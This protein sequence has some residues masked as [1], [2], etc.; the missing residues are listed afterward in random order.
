MSSVEKRKYPSPPK[1][2]AGVFIFM[3]A[4]LAFFT[5]MALF[6]F[7]GS[8][9]IP[10][11][12]ALAVLVLWLPIIGP[13]TLKVAHWYSPDPQ[14]ELI[15]SL[16]DETPTEFAD[17][18]RQ[19]DRPL[20]SLGFRLAGD[21]RVSNAM[22]GGTTFVALFEN[23]KERQVAQVITAI[24]VTAHVRKTVTLLLFSTEF[25]DQTK[26]S[27][28]NSPQSI[29]IPLLRHREGSHSFP[30]I[31]SPHR[32]FEI[33]QASIARFGGDA[34]RVAP[35]IDDPAEFL[36]R[37][38]R[39]EADTFVDTGYYYED[40]KYGIYRPTWRG[41]CL[42]AWKSTWP[43]KPIRQFVRKRRAAEFLR[44]LGLEH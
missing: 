33:H 32:L 3:S 34:A 11:W 16:I 35:S 36:R 44:A 8:G 23:A 10:V 43:I 30:W 20:E 2:S 1:P 25:N 7:V 21:L 5:S 14:V 40:P 41:A 17:A 37:S 9:A 12:I 19:V 38:M 39:A 26:L 28:R 4:I 13:V 29:V 24:A 31:K 18:V 22:P 15:N 27:T 6:H 42:M